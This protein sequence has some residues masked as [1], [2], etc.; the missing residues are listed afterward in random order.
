MKSEII[1]FLEEEQEITFLIGTSKEDNDQV[2]NKGNP[3]DIW[4]HAR[5]ISSCHVLAI[6]SN[7]DIKLD[8]KEIKQIIRKGAELVRQHTAKLRSVNKIE[9]IYT[10]ISYVEKT[11][12][13]GCVN[14]D[15]NHQKTIRI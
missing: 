5:G 15:P 8:K 9:I 13:K 11:K 2:I 1:T 14:I 10:D 4:F 6:L 7:L 12:H 3:G